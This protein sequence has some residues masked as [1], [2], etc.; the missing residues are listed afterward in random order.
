MTKNDL[1]AKYQKLD[2][3][4]HVLKRPNMYIGN[5]E[6]D[7]CET[8]VLDEQAV[9]MKKKNLTYIPG[10]YKIFDEILVNA[11]DHSVLQL[12]VLFPIVA[13]YSK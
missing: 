1:A 4:E 8:W 6:K 9:A 12:V 5:I 3:R 7:V 2:H 10:L 13:S 11:I